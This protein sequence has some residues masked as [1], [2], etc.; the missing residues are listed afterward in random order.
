MLEIEKQNFHQTPIPGRLYAKSSAMR[1]ASIL[2]ALNLHLPH[3]PAA[4]EFFPNDCS[5]AAGGVA[6]FSPHMHTY[7]N[8]RMITA[9]PHH[10]C[11]AL[12]GMKIFLL[13]KTLSRGRPPPGQY[14]SVAAAQ[15]RGIRKREKMLMCAC[16]VVSLSLSL[17][18]RYLHTPFWE[19][20]HASACSLV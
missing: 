18:V 9:H 17:A 13:P 8:M 6:F 4:R 10:I 11:N 16:W 7:M 15:R 20:T 3:F 14:A 2:H 1:V 12:R 19:A 5:R